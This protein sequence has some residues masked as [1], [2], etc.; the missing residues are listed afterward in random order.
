MLR[1]ER[2]ARMCLPV[3]AGALVAAFRKG[4]KDVQSVPL[5]NVY[6]RGRIQGL[7]G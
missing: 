2:G 3:E 5:D 7:F 4:A 1:L 6:I